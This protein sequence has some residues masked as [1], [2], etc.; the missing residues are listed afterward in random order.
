[1]DPEGLNPAA[2]VYRAG[3]GGYRIGEMINPYVQPYIASALDAM[4]LPDFDDPSIILA[5]NNKQTR[6]R[7]QGLQDIID[8]HKKQL[9]KE[10]NCPASDHWRNEIKVWQAEIDR[11]R[12]RLPNGK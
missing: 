2:A 1:M 12:L 10:P 7:I 11:L 9:D 4:F 5:Q 6:K 8:K 3:T